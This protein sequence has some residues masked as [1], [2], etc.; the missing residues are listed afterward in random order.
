MKKIA[1]LFFVATMPSAYA[2]G[3]F[4]IHIGPGTAPGGG[5]KL[6]SAYGTHICWSEANI[7]HKCEVEGNDFLDGHDAYFRLKRQD[8]CPHT[9]L[10]GT[11]TDF[12]FK[13]RMK[14]LL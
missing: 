1:V 2:G 14:D 6:L 8:C 5:A 12:K 4:S 3:A 11:T 9:L 13:V 10:G 7:G